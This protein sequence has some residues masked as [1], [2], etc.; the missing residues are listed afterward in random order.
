MLPSPTPLVRLLSMEELIGSSF[1]KQSLMEHQPQQLRVEPQAENTS[2]FDMIPSFT[3][4]RRVFIRGQLVGPV[5][6]YLSVWLNRQKRREGKEEN[7]RKLEVTFRPNESIIPPQ[8]VWA[9]CVQC[10][11]QWGSIH[12]KFLIFYAMFH[13]YVLCSL[14]KSQ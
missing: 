2:R 5:W 12:N 8:Q 14:L 9:Y 4:S 3:S 6:F 10:A 7:R 13:C 1:S 11:A